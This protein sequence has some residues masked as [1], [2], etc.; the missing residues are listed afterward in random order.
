MRELSL[1]ILDLVQNSLEAGASQVDL[2]IIED[3][4]MNRMSIRVSDNGCGM[5]EITQQRVTDPFVTSR[6][7]RKIG[8]GLPLLDMTTKQCGGSLS[9]SSSIG[10][11]SVVEAVYQLSHLDR[12]PLGNIADTIQAIIIANSNLHFTYRHV[13]EDQVFLVESKHIRDVLGDIP[14]T[15][16]D[17]I[18]WLRNY[19]TDG[20]RCLY[21]GVEDENT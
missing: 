21:G 12:P 15:D 2:E 16:P 19:I 1:H 5:D 13:V 17:V 6:T 8:L 7:T 9:I 20:V 10:R 18:T 11:G 3:T 4:K 14:L